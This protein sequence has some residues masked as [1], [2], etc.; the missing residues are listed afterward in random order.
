MDPP[1]SS[2]SFSERLAHIKRKTRSRTWL[3][4][5]LGTAYLIGGTSVGII[6][7]GEPG[8]DIRVGL[9]LFSL[10][11][12]FA[13]VATVL[14]IVRLR[15]DYVRLLLPWYG[16]PYQLWLIGAP[17]SGEGTPAVFAYGWML[18]GT[19]VFVVAT[20]ATLATTRP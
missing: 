7:S 12:L 1:R 8:S 4:L 6:F 17:P 18:L 11:M 16:L 20:L 3:R 19:L 10:S 13:G 2:V 9:R 5:I 15:L 14:L